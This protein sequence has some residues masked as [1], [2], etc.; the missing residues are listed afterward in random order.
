MTDQVAEDDEDCFRIFRKYLDYMPSNHEELPPVRPAPEGSEERMA[1]ILDRFPDSRRR[2]YDMHRIIQCIVDGGD[3]LELK[4]NFGAMLIT[5]L[6][7]INGEVVGFIASNPIVGLGATNTDALEKSTGFMCLCDSFN[8]PL[9]FL[10]DTPG[11]LTGKEAERQRVGSRVVNNL[12][13]L[14]QVTAPK[15]SIVIRKNYGQAMMNMSLL[16]SGYDFSV[17]WPTG[18]LSFLDPD[19]AADVINPKLPEEEREKMRKLMDADATPYPAARGYWLQDIIHPLDT[20]RYLIDVLQI[21]RDSAQRGM[22][23]HLLANWPKML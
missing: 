5:C 22:S 16:G 11:H 23:R 1:K 4:P 21:V 10:S 15:I 17:S 14:F 9:I 3:I 20:R 2:A 19:I 12:Q 13:A 8:I 6:A 7:R 18:E